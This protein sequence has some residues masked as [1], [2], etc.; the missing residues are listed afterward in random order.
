MVYFIFLF[1]EIDLIS[2]YLKYLKENELEH[3]A[4]CVLFGD[5]LESNLVCQEGICEPAWLV[6][7]PFNKHTFIV[8]I[9]LDVLGLVEN[10]P[11]Y[12]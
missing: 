5:I 8:D 6:P 4:L 12:R 9:K 1:D 7:L 10:W 2:W 3:K 11:S